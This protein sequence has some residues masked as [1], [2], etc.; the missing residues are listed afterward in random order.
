MFETKNYHKL[1]AATMAAASA[2]VAVTPVAAAAD[3][4]VFPDVEPDNDHYDS[5]LKLKNDGIVIGDNGMFKPYE[6]ITRGQVAA[7][8]MKALDLEL[9]APE[10]GANLTQYSDVSPLGSDYAY[11]IAAVTEAGIFH[12]DNGKFHT[13]TNI[14]REQMATVLVKAFNLDKIDA[15][16]VPLTDKNISDSHRANVQVLANLN[17]TNQTDDFQ[18]YD[19]ILRQQFATMVVKSMEASGVTVTEDIEVNSIGTSEAAALTENTDGGRDFEATIR[20]WNDA[21]APEGTDVYVTIP[22]DKLQGHVQLKNSDGQTVTAEDGEA[23]FNGNPENIYALETDKDGTINFTLT[24]EMD[25]YAQPT[26][27]I[28][29]GDEKGELDAED[30]QATGEMTSFSEAVFKN[31]TFKALDQNEEKVEDV[32]AGD[33]ASFV[34]QLLDQNGKMSTSLE[35]TP[36]FEVKN[37]GLNPVE[38]EGQTL[39]Q[40]GSE[41]MQ[42]DSENGKA[43]MNLTAQGPAHI[44]VQAS[45]PETSIPDKEAK[46]QFK[47]GAELK[48]GMYYTGTGNLNED[49][50]EAK[51]LTLYIN[52]HR[53]ELP[54]DEA[55]LYF[56][57]KQV[58]IDT[59]EEESM[60]AS[61]YVFYNSKSDENDQ[62][63]LT[64]NLHVANGMLG[65]REMPTPVPSDDLK[66]N[67]LEA[68]IEQPPGMIGTYH[69]VSFRGTVA[70]EDIEEVKE[71]TVTF[72]H[73]QSEETGDRETRTIYVNEYGMFAGSLSQYPFSGGSYIEDFQFY[74]QLTITYT[75]AKGE[76]KSVTKDYEF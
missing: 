1:A 61:T 12:G 33:E 39:P 20:G 16:E 2:V 19:N 72:S 17:I 48:E 66:I 30:T 35:H 53:H 58:S 29:N 11:Q 73:K 76:E 24:G 49:D 40:Y 52:D 18:A 22:D 6:P 68:K 25:A 74:E 55:D 10:V 62:F 69:N 57:R 43:I 34:Y 64:G 9:K 3:D 71:A 67:S 59:F 23:R 5:I 26:I 28:D 32:Q 21:L 14:T 41:T 44:S 46:L 50:R 60:H 4:T 56:K 54:Y 13:Y 38:I 63:N 31:S 42:I 75:N 37:L 15:D 65:P 70:F 51:K 7:I 27:F 8:L 45:T 36:T 47:A